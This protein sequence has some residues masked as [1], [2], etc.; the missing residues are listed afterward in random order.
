MLRKLV[1]AAVLACLCTPAGAVAE[2]EKKPAKGKLGNVDKSKVFDQMDA[3]KDGKITEDEFKKA[4]EAMAE[5]LK[6]KLPAGATGMM[7][8][9]LDG[10]FEK[11][12][13][14]KDG[15]LTKEEFEKGGFDPEQLKKLVEKL[16]DKKKG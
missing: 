1:L 8:K 2:D 3:D 7:E 14:D 10:Q 16:K 5:K 13:A 11:M 6:D 15:K 12:D 4:R 9:L